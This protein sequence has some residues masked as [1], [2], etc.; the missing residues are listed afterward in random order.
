MRGKNLS[1]TPLK[2]EDLPGAADLISNPGETF[3][4]AQL[5]CVQKDLLDVWFKNTRENNESLYFCIRPAELDEIIGICQLYGIDHEAGS[6]ELF[7]S[8]LDSVSQREAHLF[9]SAFLLLNFA[10][11][12]LALDQVF[13]NI[14]N[15]YQETTRSFCEKGFRKVDSHENV[16]IDGK[17][18]DVIRLSISRSDYQDR[19][20]F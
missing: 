16:R 3:Y 9:E 8:L 20:T 17:V 14:L 11:R 5:D 1:I 7:I 13:I 4:K 10:F 6:A 19:E 15:K 2:L 12:E 18:M